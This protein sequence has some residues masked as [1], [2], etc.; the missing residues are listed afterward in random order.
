MKVPYLDLKKTYEQITPD[1]SVALEKVLRSGR[2]VLGN[3]VR[4]FEK[5]YANFHGV[6]Y[7]AGVA[8]GLDALVLSLM[9]LGVGK[10]DEV[11][12]PSNTYIA[13]LIAVSKVG[14][15]PVPVEPNILTYNIDPQKIERVITKKTKAIVPVHLYGQSCDMDFI[16]KIAKKHKLFVVEDN[17]QSHGAYFKKKMTG[18]FGDINA[19][20]FYPGKNLGAIGD[21][22][23]I[24]TNNKKLYDKIILLRNYGESKR[25][26]NPMIGMNSRLDEIQAAFLKIRLS[27]LPRIIRSKNRIASLYLSGLTDVGDIILP[28]V[29]ENSTHVYHVFCIRTNKRNEIK[30][31]LDDRGITTI[32]H[33]PIPPHLQGAYR[34]LNYRKG[35]FPIAE[36]LARTS[37]SL[38][39]FPEMSDAQIEYVISTIKK[40]YA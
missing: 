11:I 33:Y 20:S 31:Y 4:D 14:A 21:G 24:T 2:V 16:L 13:T 12:V 30:K 18:S 8:N 23:A 26:V 36:K 19:T 7:A 22:G 15:V 25:Y 35:S 37:I 17:A 34:H 5:K 39:I 27:T 32:I 40:F 1:L 3:E 9:A 38:P 29:Q 28:Q 6:R 10:G